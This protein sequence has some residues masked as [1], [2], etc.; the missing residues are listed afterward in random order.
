MREFL[1]DKD[2]GVRATAVVTL[3]SSAPDMGLQAAR[4]L[5]GDPDPSVRAASARILGES[6]DPSLVGVLARAFEDPDWQVRQQAV[7]SAASLGGAAASSALLAAL[8]DPVGVV[9]LAAVRGLGRLGGK[10]EGEGEGLPDLARLILEDEDW[11][12]RVEA[13]KALGASARPEAYP[14]LDTALSDASEFVRAEAWRALDALRR[15][16]V[17]RPRAATDPGTKTGAP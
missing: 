4:S 17:A 9:R 2:P 7:A 10:G 8:T 6:G 1:E 12:V 16:G 15:A 13:A 3:A 11:E 5:L 14:A